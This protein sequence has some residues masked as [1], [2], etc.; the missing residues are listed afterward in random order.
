MDNKSF[1]G[2]LPSSSWSI[3]LPILFCSE[4]VFGCEDFVRKADGLVE[5]FGIGMTDGHG[6]SSCVF[7][8]VML[9]CEV[10]YGEC[11]CRAVYVVPPSYSS[12]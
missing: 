8:F 7:D 9:C 5:G 1:N 11:W 2:N 3:Y 12:C 10:I 4:S 6:G